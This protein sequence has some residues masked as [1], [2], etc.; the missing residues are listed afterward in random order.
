MGIFDTPEH[1]PFQWDG[2]QPA[3][4]LVHGFPGTPAEVRPLAL[5]LH[6]A[7][8][9]ARGLLLPGFGAEFDTLGQRRY[10]DW[11]QA[12]SRAV[13]QLRQEHSPILVI[14]FSMGA[15]VATLAT[16]AEH[17][18]DG[19][20]L[21]APFTGSVGL[22]NAIFPLMRR[23][24]PSIKPF[25]LFRLDF[26]N[27]EIRRGLA[28]FAPGLDLDDPAVQHA[29]TR[30]ALPTASLDEARRAGQAARRA[31]AGIRVPTLVIQGAQDRVVWP[32]AT[33]AFLD[34]F[35]CPVRYR[36]IAGSHDLLDSS[37][38]GWLLVQKLVLDFAHSLAANA[39]PDRKTN[40]PLQS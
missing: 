22:L 30:L 12:I 28:N 21:L 1:Q 39:R 24:L 20:V 16:S 19:L 10:P 3:V 33:R 6:A 31:A 27:P 9:T 40:K 15:A 23:T 32:Q 26:S 25:R 35:T 7:G 13:H 37:R 14:G 5:A 29:I 2:G 17:S 34:G 8:W 18:P 36:E 11:V 38:P 4:V